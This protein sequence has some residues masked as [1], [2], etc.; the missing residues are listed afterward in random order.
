MFGILAGFVLAIAVAKLAYMFMPK[1]K[2]PKPEP[3]QDMEA[4]T[5]EAGRPI[6][7]VF[8][9]GTLKSPNTLYYCEL[10]TREYEVDA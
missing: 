9:E 3:A 7:I 2:Q 6:P 8:G 10:V 4:P 5:A 1:P